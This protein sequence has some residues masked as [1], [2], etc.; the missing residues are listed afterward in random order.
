MKQ[1]WFA[2]S[3][4]AIAVGLT[5][6]ASAA[7]TLKAAHYLS[8][9]H[10]V[11]V[12]YE[13]F[14]SEVKKDTKG[15]VAVRIFPAES[16]LG[17][18][19]ISDGIRDGVADV[20]FATFTYTPSYYPHGILLNDLAMVGED[21]MAAAMA[22]TELFM[23]HCKACTAEFDKQNQIFGG[24]M[25]TAPYVLVAKGDLNSLEKI[26]GKKLRAGGS[27]WD[28]F[29]TSVGATGVNVPSSEIYESLSRGIIDAAIYAVGG[30]KTHG[31]AD[32]ADH[33][34]MLNLGSFRSGN[35]Y[36]FN[37]DTWSKLTTEQRAAIFKALPVA[38]VRTVDEYHL[39]D[40]VAL[41]LAKQKKIPVEQPDASLLKARKEFVEKDLP[42]VIENAKNKL[43]IDD[44]A[45]F[46]AKYKELLAKYEKLVKPIE[47]DQA[48]LS[49]MFYKEVYAKLDPAKYGVK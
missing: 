1:A 10:P 35:L 41:E 25:S 30:L 13:A 7:T 3:I 6:G 36:A 48:K 29:A 17:A 31:L 46:V 37:K 12:G 14:A 23:L 24:G 32:A 20:G 33:V 15:E 19:A 8:P 28:R 27:L 42:G 18:K 47:S 38:I 44:A 45:Q 22:I 43:K 5:T 26:K 49:E 9:K 16:L 34:I 4:L 39:G 11:G 40:K 21:D 2:A